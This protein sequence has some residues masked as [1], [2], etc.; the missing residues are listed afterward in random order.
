MHSL[1]FRPLIVCQSYV[2]LD[3]NE[4]I[5]GFFSLMEDSLVLD[6]GDNLTL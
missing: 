5:V 1:T 4:E 6:E 2:V 3:E